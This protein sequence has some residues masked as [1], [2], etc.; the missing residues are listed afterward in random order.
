[1]RWLGYLTIR[2]RTTMKAIC[3]LAIAT[4]TLIGAETPKTFT[5]VITDTMCG[6]KPHSAMMKDKS[7]A[8]CVRLCVKGPFGYALYDGT[9]VMKLSDQKA[10]VQYAAQKVKVTGTYDQKTKM[11]KT[12]SIEPAQ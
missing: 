6:T 3:L 5:G 4:L 7:E 1:M 2:K 11:L 9:N 12:V 10:P 8:E